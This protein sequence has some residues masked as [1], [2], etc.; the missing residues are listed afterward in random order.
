MT[1]L[2]FVSVSSNISL[3]SLY[4]LLIDY[5][6]V[7]K[8]RLAFGFPFFHCL[9]WAHV[10]VCP[11][12]LPIYNWVGTRG[13]GS[14][15]VT[16]LYTHTQHIAQT[17][18]PPTEHIPSTATVCL[19]DND[20]L[21]SLGAILLNNF[22]LDGGHLMRLEGLNNPCIHLS[23]KCKCKNVD[24]FHDF[25]CWQCQEPRQAPSMS[26][27]TSTFTW[28]SPEYQLTTY[29]FILAWYLS[30]HFWW[31]LS[32][33]DKILSDFSVYFLKHLSATRDHWPCWPK[34]LLVFAW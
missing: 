7:V 14:W 1:V 20:A 13:L 31:Q 27:L 9:K 32:C 4:L 8:I 3:N 2:R 33:V 21:N 25:K 26:T 12:G 17:L 11:V 24:F 16:I 34:L 15:E 28:M 22:E 10:Y 5:Y 19:V 30:M 6:G 29:L 23:T 18:H